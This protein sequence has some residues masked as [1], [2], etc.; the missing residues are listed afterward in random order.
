M[1]QDILMSMLVEESS[2]GKK[3]QDDNDI[4]SK[5]KYALDA[6]E[7]NPN[8]EGTLAED[9]A[10]ITNIVTRLKSSVDTIVSLPDGSVAEDG[11][12]ATA[13]IGPKGEKYSTL[14][15]AITKQIAD[16]KG[17]VVSNTKPAS[18]SNV[19]VWINTSNEEDATSTIQ[20]PEI[21]DDV[22]SDVDTWSSSKID[23]M[24]KTMSTA[25]VDSNGN[26]IGLSELIDDTSVAYDKVWSSGKTRTEILAALSNISDEDGNTINLFELVD[27]EDEAFNKVWSSSKI[28]SEID[29][30]ITNVVE[31]GGVGE[32]YTLPMAS[33]TV[34]GGVK[35]GTNLVMSAGGVLSAV[36][37]TYDIATE[38]KSG[39]MSSTSYKKLNEAATNAENAVSTANTASTTASTAK[40]TAD[41]AKSTA[42]TAKSTADT[43]NTNATTANNSIKTAP[44]MLKFANK[45]VATSAWTSDSTY[46]NYPYKAAISCNGVTSS[47]VADV[48]FSIAAIEANIYAPICETG[49]GTVTIWASEKP[50]STLTIPTIICFATR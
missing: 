49:S 33:A 39:L 44:I 27:D 25:V 15:E 2:L 50:T 12:I 9:I 16:Y 22:V 35:I 18:S 43:A 6:T 4:S 8:I 7:K 34:L 31:N 11:E 23:A 20:L 30:A 38:T 1:L 21:D 10:N 19:D 29:Y 46:T 14:Q 24:I 41:T 36:D 3:I 13:K 26:S 48:I 32:P 42:D 28:R 40:S 47:Y 17:I 45:T 5:G 37:T